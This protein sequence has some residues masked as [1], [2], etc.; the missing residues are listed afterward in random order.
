MKHLAYDF[1]RFFILPKCLISV[2]GCSQSITVLQ[3]CG[4]GMWHS[5]DRL[6]CIPVSFGC[7]DTLTVV[8][9]STL[10]GLPCPALLGP[11]THLQPGLLLLIVGRSLGWVVFEGGNLGY[12]SAHSGFLH[13]TS[14]N[15]STAC[16]LGEPLVSHIPPGTCWRWQHASLS[17]PVHLGLGTSLLMDTSKSSKISP[18]AHVGCFAVAT[19]YK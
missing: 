3:T 4:Q 13:C 11:C 6:W 17:P 5:A 19:L 15:P 7:A 16:T 10:S 9:Y 1:W 2:S 8:P 12:T 14:R 18:L